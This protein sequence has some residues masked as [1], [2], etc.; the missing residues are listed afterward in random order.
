M[1]G[2]FDSTKTPLIISSVA[3]KR[4]QLIMGDR[5]QEL[6]DRIQSLSF[7]GSA[8]YKASDGDKGDVS[9]TS[10][11]CSAALLDGPVDP[12]KTS[13]VLGVEVSST[14]AACRNILHDCIAYQDLLDRLGVQ[15]GDLVEVSNPENPSISPRIARVWAAGDDVLVQGDVDISPFLAYNLGVP[16]HLA[17]FFKLKDSLNN[18]KFKVSITRVVTR[19]SALQ[20]GVDMRH[21]VNPSCGSLELPMATHLGLSVIREPDANGDFLPEMEGEEGGEHGQMNG[22][23]QDPEEEVSAMCI[24]NYF[25][26]DVQIVSLGDVIAIPIPRSDTKK[27]GLVVSSINMPIDDLENGDFSA[28]PGVLYFKVTSMKPELPLIQAVDSNHTAINLEGV[29][30]SGYPVGSRAYLSRDPAKNAAILGVSSSA[31]WLRMDQVCME[32]VGKILPVWKKVAH[33]IA[34]TFHPSSTNIR[35]KPSIL[36]SGPHGAGKRVAARAAAAA[37]GCHYISISCE[38]IRPEGMPD[39]KVVE[40]LDAVLS[41]AGNYKPVILLLRDVQLLAQPGAPNSESQGARV[42]AALSQCIVKGLN[43]PNNKDQSSNQDV[44]P[45]RVFIVGT[46]PDVDDLDSGLR[47]CFTHEISVD[48]PEVAERRLLLESFFSTIDQ[49]I[50]KEAMDNMVQHTAGFLPLELK[51]VAAEACASAV[52]DLHSELSKITAEKNQETQ[53]EESVKPPI[54]KSSHIDQSIVAVRQKTAT[55]IGAPKIPDVQWDDV[56]GLE[57]VKLG[58]L[59]TGMS[60]EM[61]PLYIKRCSNDILFPFICS[62]TSIETPRAICWRNP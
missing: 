28:P 46:V 61:I 8:L 1:D 52:L 42:G 14:A 58:I 2:S 60:G 17:P 20:D 48:A 6:S 7:A 10:I 31:S 45:G 23:F 15:S 43:D 44:F 3:T 51:N 32:H 50:Q 59:D 36:L 27:P 54:F 13:A 33:V 38:D 34:C 5:G 24:K 9:Y 37:L 4:L 40:A 56:G 12:C 55:D 26:R 62:R 21:V 49:E 57:D 47:R 41:I 19:P 53:V 30:S 29:T 16:Y 39:E 25:G 22:G 35:M 18:N 11:E